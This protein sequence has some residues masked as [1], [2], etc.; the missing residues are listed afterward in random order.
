MFIM[1]T[2]QQVSIVTV[3]SLQQFYCT[4]L[5]FSNENSLKDHLSF[6]F[7]ISNIVYCTLVAIYIYN[8][9][10]NIHTQWTL[11][12]VFDL[13]IPDWLQTCVKEARDCLLLNTTQPDI[14]LILLTLGCKSTRFCFMWI[15]IHFKAF[16]DV[17]LSCIY[18]MK[19]LLYFLVDADLSL[20]FAWLHLLLLQVCLSGVIYSLIKFP[21]FCRAVFLE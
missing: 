13:L 14:R 15:F 21:Y 6:L 19:Y 18:H 1:G 10:R 4:S 17:H 11:S 2:Y 16:C 5:K 8:I 3:Y 12:S 9:Y 20:F 7:G